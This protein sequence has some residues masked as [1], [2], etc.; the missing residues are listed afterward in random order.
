M[1][2]TALPVAW[3]GVILDRA[4]SL[5]VVLGRALLVRR[6]F[7][8][9]NRRYLLERGIGRDA[10]LIRSRVTVCT[11]NWDLIV[12]RT[13]PSQEVD[14]Y[15]SRKAVFMRPDQPRFEPARL[16]GGPRGIV[17]Q[18]RKVP[19]RPKAR[20]VSRVF[21]HMARKPETFGRAPLSAEVQ[22][23]V[24]IVTG[25][26]S[27]LKQLAERPVRAADRTASQSRSDVEAALEYVFVQAAS[28]HW[29]K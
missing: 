6:G 1:P 19:V 26:P 14:P 4:S 13:R 15:T 17:S 28:P 12:H 21:G 16:A 27:H 2:A 11:P 3:L 29:R 10:A 18:P 25:N 5:L 9:D 22:P 20:S 8:A 24:L 23:S 7:S